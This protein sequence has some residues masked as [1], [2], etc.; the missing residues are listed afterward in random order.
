MTLNG[1]PQVRESLPFYRRAIDLDPENAKAIYHLGIHLLGIGS[2]KGDQDEPIYLFTRAALLDPGVSATEGN[3]IRIMEL[4][5][6]VAA[7]AAHWEERARKTGSFD[8]LWTAA[9]LRSIR[10]EIG[11]EERSVL[12]AARL[13]FERVLCRE[14]GTLSAFLYRGYVRAVDR[15][16]DLARQDLERV[17][18]YYPSC[19]FA[20]FAFAVA[21]AR[22]GSAKEA[23]AHLAKAIELDTAVRE[24][25][26]RHAELEGLL[27]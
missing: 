23:K 3:T 8:D 15:Q 7:E 6:D 1:N 13:A 12:D 21:E 4:G 19:A 22:G 18:R 5:T 24:R 16:T 9:R 2:E 11:H 10:V 25:T 27:R 14:P 20:W 17:V 26:K